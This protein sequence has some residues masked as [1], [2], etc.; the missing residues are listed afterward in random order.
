MT[1]VICEVRLAQIRRGRH[2]V[3]GSGVKR[4]R[5]RCADLLGDNGWRWWVLRTSNAYAFQGSPDGLF[6]LA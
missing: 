2:D 3:G 4:V 1:A 5:E 6:K